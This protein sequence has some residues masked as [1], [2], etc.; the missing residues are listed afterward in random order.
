[1]RYATIQDAVEQY[2]GPSL[3]DFAEDYDM[4]AIAREAFQCVVDTDENGAE[5]L[6]TAGFQLRVVTDDAYWDIV[7]RHFRP[8]YVF[9]DT[10]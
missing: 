3:G 7:E 2:V 9:P 5:H 6:T 1:M 4:D 10:E 8:P